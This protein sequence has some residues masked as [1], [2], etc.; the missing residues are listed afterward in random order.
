MEWD[1]WYSATRISANISTT[2]SKICGGK[3][4]EVWPRWQDFCRLAPSRVR[5]EGVTLESMITHGLNPQIE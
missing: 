3:V 5:D 4:S 2:A 1:E